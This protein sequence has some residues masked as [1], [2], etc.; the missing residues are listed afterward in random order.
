MMQSNPSLNENDVSDPESDSEA[1]SS[2]SESD[3]PCGLS[4]VDPASSPASLPKGPAVFNVK[5]IPG[6]LV[7]GPNYCTPTKEAMAMLMRQRIPVRF[8]Q[9]SHGRHKFYWDMFEHQRGQPY[10]GETKQQFEA[11]GSP[12][13]NT[14]PLVILDQQLVGGRDQLREFLKMPP[15]DLRIMRERL[16][17]ACTRTIAIPPNVDGNRVQERLIEEAIEAISN[18]QDC[19]QYIPCQTEKPPHAS[20]SVGMNPA[21]IHPAS[22]VAEGGKQ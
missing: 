4:A 3:S 2:D 8:V 14:A 1:E 22:M 15:L 18:D 6:F 17:G 10:L 12:P 16:A 20:D 7:I 21:D 13:H 5:H 19:L 9:A 11:R